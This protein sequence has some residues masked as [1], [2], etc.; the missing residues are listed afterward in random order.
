MGKQELFRIT[1]DNHKLLNRLENAASQ[2]T[3]ST[4]RLEEC[5]LEN[6]RHMANASYDS[7]ARKAGYYDAL[8]RP[9][10]SRSTPDLRRNQQKMLMP[11]DEDRPPSRGQEQEQQSRQ[12]SRERP[13]SREM[14]EQRPPSRGEVKASADFEEAYSEAFD[15]DDVASYAVDI[16]KT[17]INEG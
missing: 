3:F 10:M 7:S 14:I 12:P 17:D 15:E 16:L 8:L 11:P 4:K 2:S 6:R 5:H 9:S 1:M 13:R